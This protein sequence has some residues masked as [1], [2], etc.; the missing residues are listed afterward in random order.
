MSVYRSALGKQ[1]DMSALASRNEKVRAV[2]NMRVNARGDT[3]DGFGRV[4]RPNTEK[5]N[6]QYSKSV[7]NRSAQPVKQSN[8]Q[9]P[10]K[11]VVKEQ[12]TDYE[13]ELEDNFT[14]DLEVER[15][16]ANEMSKK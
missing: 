8:V 5:V 9:V 6:E 13:R 3:I 15:I 7:G 1:V 14:D 11:P 10:P 2:G 12:L 16:K 4:I